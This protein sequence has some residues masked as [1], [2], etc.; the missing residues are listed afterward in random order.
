MRIG[1]SIQELFDSNNKDH[2]E[3]SELLYLGMG[4][5]QARARGDETYTI[6]ANKLQDEEDLDAKKINEV[7]SAIVKLNSIVVRAY[8]VSKEFRQRQDL[9]LRSVTLSGEESDR[10]LRYQTTWERRLSSAIGEL[11]ALQGKSSK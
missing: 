4:V 7:L 6:K 2:S 10:L 11:L 9:M 1:N 5:M 3:L 8:E